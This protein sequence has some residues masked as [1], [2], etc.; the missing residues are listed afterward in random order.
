MPSIEA[1]RELVRSSFDAERIEPE[2]LDEG[3]IA[4]V[5]P[6]GCQVFD[7]SGRRAG[8]TFRRMQTRPEDTQRGDY[9][10]YMLKEIHQQ[11]DVVRHSLQESWPAATDQPREA[12]KH[13]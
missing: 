6:Q 9:A 10:H 13:L 8:P 4:E 12:T 5:S 7:R 2:H 1:A 11:P 3:D